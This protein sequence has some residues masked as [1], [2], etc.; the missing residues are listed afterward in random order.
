MSRLK[1]ITPSIVSIQMFKT[2]TPKVNFVDVDTVLSLK[3]GEDVDESLWRV[4]N[5]NDPSYNVDLLEAY[6][7]KGIITRIP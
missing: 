3:P 2:P 4:S 1:N 5:I 7:E 6:I